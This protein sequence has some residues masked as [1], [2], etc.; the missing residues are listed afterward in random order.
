MPPTSSDLHDEP[1]RIFADVN[2]LG[3]AGPNTVP[4]GNDTELLQRL[5]RLPQERERFL[6][7]EDGSLE[8]EGTARAEEIAGRRFWILDIEPDTLRHLD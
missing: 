5:G 3:Q 8:A 7:V 6:A 1:T 2:R 4:L